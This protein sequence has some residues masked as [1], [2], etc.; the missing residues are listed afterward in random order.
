M[1]GASGLDYWLQ[2]PALVCAF[3]VLVAFISAMALLFKYEGFRRSS[4][5]GD[6][7]RA[8]NV[9]DEELWRPCWKT[10]HPAGL[11][12]YRAVVFFVM[13]AILVTNLV[14]DGVFIFYFYTQWT[15]TLVIIYFGLAALISAKGCSELSQKGSRRD[16]D[17]RAN[18][19]KMDPQEGMYAAER[20]GENINRGAIKLQSC[21]ELDENRK[22]A[23]CWG[24]TMQVL[25]QTCA[26]AVMLTD[27][28]FWFIIVPFLT[29]KD[30]SLNLL[31]GSMH[32]INVL[33]LLIDTVFNSMHFPWFRGAYFVLWSALYIVF[34]WIVHAC[35][36][37]WWP[38]P[39]L[40]LSTAWAP[41][42]YC[43]LALVHIP[44]YGLF[45]LL[46]KVKEGLF[47]KWFP[48]AYQILHR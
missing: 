36:F 3:L 48:N 22:R 34:Q 2:W 11:L 46:I 35:G 45:V 30:F 40:E 6:L 14:R 13:A 4:A 17:E 18:F 8:G 32:S 37:K 39:F 9:H 41:L 5:Q 43:A 47:P 26:G 27:I 24:Y 33:L 15:F 10:I 42:W 21:Q 44:C 7:R 1:A 19:L 12:A 31:M 38:Y 23:G 28:V 20:P 16:A 29:T 25:F